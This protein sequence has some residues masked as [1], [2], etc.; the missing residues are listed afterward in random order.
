[1]ERGDNQHSGIP[2]VIPELAVRVLLIICGLQRDRDT[3]GDGLWGKI[4]KV[5]ATEALNP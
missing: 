2:D 4:Y 3:M 5:F 1:M